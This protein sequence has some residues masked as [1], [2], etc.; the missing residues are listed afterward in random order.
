MD[1]VRVGQQ[2]PVS[3][4]N[5]HTERAQE[6]MKKEKQDLRSLPKIEVEGE[7]DAENYQ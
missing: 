4:P 1:K 6:G 3:P 7:N 5:A 2:T